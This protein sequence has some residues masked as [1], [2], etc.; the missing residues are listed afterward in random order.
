MYK[1]VKSFSVFVFLLVLISC[2]QYFKN[3][4][5]ELKEEPIA[6]VNDLYLYPSDINGLSQNADK[7]DSAKL[8]QMFVTDWIKRNLL[9]EKAK[10]SLPNSMKEIDEKVENYRQ[11]LILYNY[12]SELL[13]EMQ[14]TSIE[15]SLKQKYYQDFQNN[16][17]LE[18]DVFQFQ[19]IALPLNTAQLEDWIEV[20]S[21]TKP[22]DKVTL[23]SKVKIGAMKAELSSSK[24]F[25][26]DELNKQIEL[27]IDFFAKLKVNSNILKLDNSTQVILYKLNAVKPIGEVAPFDRVEKSINQIL[28]NKKRTELLNKMYQEIY[29]KGIQTKTA[30]DFTISKSKK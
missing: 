6:R 28:L 2:C 14:D 7:N 19:Y 11:S 22:E 25:T 26:R 1:I 18:E 15:N 5:K 29:Q 8:V 16:F 4:T 12:E 3:K 21:S 30:E 10:E 27:P 13:S 23:N 17:V 20:F 24:W 9:L